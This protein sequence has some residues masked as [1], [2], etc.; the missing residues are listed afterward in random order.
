MTRRLQNT[1]ERLIS[2]LGA[3]LTIIGAVVM[4]G[5]TCISTVGVESAPVGAEIYVR[6]DKEV[7]FSP[8]PKVAGGVSN[9][10]TATTPENLTFDWNYLDSLPANGAEERL[11]VKVIFPGGIETKPVEILRCENA[12]LQFKGT[13]GDKERV[14]LARVV[15]DRSRGC[16]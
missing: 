2:A 8:V 7:S 5:C 12:R 13:T 15:R 10:N 1:Q 16:L 4:T 14:E 3:T 6:G 9:T 11:W